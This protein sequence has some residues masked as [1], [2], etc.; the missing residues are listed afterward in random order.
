MEMY[1]QWGRKVAKAHLWMEICADLIV[2]TDSVGTLAVV[3]TLG[4]IPA[5]VASQ[6]H[7][8]VAGRGRC[9]RVVH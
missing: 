3:D 6:R 8:T 9:E 2:V 7:T 4:E 5:I 1:Q